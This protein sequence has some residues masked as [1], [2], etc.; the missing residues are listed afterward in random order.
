VQWWQAAAAQG[1]AQ[2]QLNLGMSSLLSIA[3]SQALGQS[4]ARAS[5]GTAYYTGKGVGR[6]LSEAI[7]YFEKAEAQNNPNAAFMLGVCYQHTNPALSKQWFGRAR[8]VMWSSQPQELVA[9]ASAM[10]VSDHFSKWH[11]LNFHQHITSGFLDAGRSLPTG[12]DTG[13]EVIVIIESDAALQS[14]VTEAQQRLAHVSGV[15]QILFCS[16]VYR[17]THRLDFLLCS[18]RCEAARSCPVS[19]R[20]RGVWWQ[21]HRLQVRS[22][23]RL[24][25]LC[26]QSQRSPPASGFGWLH[27][28]AAGSLSPPIASVQ[29]PVRPYA[30]LSTEVGTDRTQ[31]RPYPRSHSVSVGAWRAA[32]CGWCGPK[33]RVEC[34][35]AGA[36]IVRGRC[37]E[38][39][40]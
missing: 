21:Q 5:S 31:I 37:N 28:I 9:S 10:S 26:G 24:C 30:S 36:R 34:G 40:G 12:L 6:N 25:H 16:A 4:A 20:I 23:C 39:C 3:L 18:G 17:F 33:S 19:V 15:A 14:C 29:V 32:L 35:A 2:A 7:S 8:H 1:F 13:R 38:P 11:Y 22:T 27:S